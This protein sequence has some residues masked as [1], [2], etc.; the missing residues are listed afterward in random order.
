[1]PFVLCSKVLALSWQLLSAAHLAP[2]ASTPCPPAGD[3][4]NIKGRVQHVGEDGGI[5]V[6]PQVGGPRCG[7][8]QLQRRLLKPVPY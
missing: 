8:G 6:E 2:R 4:K 5:M 7:C 1:M 3:L